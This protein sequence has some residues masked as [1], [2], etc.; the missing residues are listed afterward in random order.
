MNQP[1]RESGTPCLLSIDYFPMRYPCQSIEMTVLFNV[2]TNAPRSDSSSASWLS[3]RTYTITDRQSNCFPPKHNN[4]KNILYPKNINIFQFFKI[5][6][7]SKLKIFEM[8]VKSRMPR[9]NPQRPELY[10]NQ[11]ELFR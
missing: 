2:K 7:V 10:R 3:Y 11:M 5:I 4:I 6:F 1:C 8:N 9:K